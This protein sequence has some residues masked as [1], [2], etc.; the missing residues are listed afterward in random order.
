MQTIHGIAVLFHV[1]HALARCCSYGP[2]LFIVGLTDVEGSVRLAF[3][4][5]ETASC[6]ITTVVGR[7]GLVHTQAS[8]QAVCCTA[9]GA[10]EVGYR[11]LEGQTLGCFFKLVADIVDTF[12]ISAAL[13]IIVFQ[14]LVVGNNL[15]AQQQR[16]APVE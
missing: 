14:F 5:A 9:C 12:V 6:L 15:I 4:V 11:L 8:Y 16:G 10:T 1:H 13:T 2:A 3:P 7:A